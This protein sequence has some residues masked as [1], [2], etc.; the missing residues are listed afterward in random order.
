VIAHRGASGHL[1]ENT[2]PAFELAVAQGADMIETDLHRTAD[3]AVVVTHDED[4]AGLGGS[5]EIAEASLAEVRALDAGGGERVPT[6]DELLDRFGARVAWNL[7]LKRGTRGEYAGLE[8][9]ALA[10]VRARGLEP[11]TLFSSFY[12]PVLARL[13]ALAP[14]ARIGLLVSR[15]LPARAVERALALGAEA[16]HPE[17]AVVDAALVDAAHAA[18]LAVH[19]FTVDDAAEMR[20]L[21]GLGVDGL[22][23]NF[24][25][26]MRRVLGEGV[27]PGESIRSDS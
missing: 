5:G 14:R 27:P 22:F 13:R 21:L 3:G 10:A 20:R 12:D 23:T 11:R 26:R 17:A 24:P 16:L 4:L 19:V 15:R 7:E 1:P 8:E 6:L 25:D 18:G 9:A 2:P